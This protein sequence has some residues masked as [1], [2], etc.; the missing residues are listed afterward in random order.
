MP[1]VL[2]IVEL[3]SWLVRPEVVPL[4]G[5]FCVVIAAVLLRLLVF[6]HRKILGLC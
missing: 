2:G 6:R 4:I 1:L 3:W 5:A